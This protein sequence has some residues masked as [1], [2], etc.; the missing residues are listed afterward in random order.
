MNKSH[1]HATL[2]FTISILYIADH[3]AIAIMYATLAGT[4]L[5]FSLRK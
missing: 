4:E 3:L 2:Y 5:I 1:I